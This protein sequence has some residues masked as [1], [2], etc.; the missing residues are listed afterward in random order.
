MTTQQ[1]C[2]PLDQGTGSEKTGRWIGA[3]KNAFSQYSPTDPTALAAWIRLQHPNFKH[4]VLNSSNCVLDNKRKINVVQKGTDFHG[5]LHERRHTVAR[6]F[7]T[8]N[9]NPLSM[10]PTVSKRNPWCRSLRAAAHAMST[11]FQQRSTK[12]SWDTLL[13]KASNTNHTRFL[14]LHLRH[15]SLR[16]P[17]HGLIIGGLTLGHDLMHA[18]SGGVPSRWN[19]SSKFLFWVIALSP[20]KTWMRTRPV[21]SVRRERLSLLRERW[22]CVR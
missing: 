15:H 13:L 14:V 7:S 4:S 3:F 11:N 17:V 5:R 1:A 21:V 19:F 9:A 2:L 22:C 8:A 12:H 6:D 16:G 10:G 18:T 20:S